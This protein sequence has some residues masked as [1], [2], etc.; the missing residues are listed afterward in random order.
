M[1]FRVT[2]VLILI[3]AVLGGYMALRPRTEVED[4]ASL[5]P[6]FYIV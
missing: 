2:S 1:S 4:S 6:W 5:R 3:V